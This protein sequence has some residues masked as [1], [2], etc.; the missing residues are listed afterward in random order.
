VQIILLLRQ[1]E[2]SSSQA[3]LANISL[4]TIAHQAIIDAYLCLLHLTTGLLHPA[5]LVQALL[6]IP[7]TL[8]AHPSCFVTLLLHSSF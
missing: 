6:V 3:H 7:S 2:A 8:Q 5:V 1:I 4:L